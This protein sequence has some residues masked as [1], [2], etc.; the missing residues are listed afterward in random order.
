MSPKKKKGPFEYKFLVTVTS[1][2]KMSEER[3]DSVSNSILRLIQNR[4]CWYSR[5]VGIKVVTVK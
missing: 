4:E 1:M 3:Q 5:V 2:N